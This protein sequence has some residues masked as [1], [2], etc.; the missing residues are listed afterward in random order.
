[1]PPRLERRADRDTEAT[2]LPGSSIV[3]H[4]ELITFEELARLETAGAPVVL[5]DVRSDSGYA[6]SPLTAKGAIRLNPSNPVD[7]AA[8]RALPRES[9]LV[10]YCS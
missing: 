4:P 3:E 6:A 5:L 2:G 9:W 8:A 10:A 1:M 7:S